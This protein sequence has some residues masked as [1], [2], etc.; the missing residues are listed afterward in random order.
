MFLF[1]PIKLTKILA[2][3][4]PVLALLLYGFFLAHKTNL[5]TSDLGRHIKNGEIVFENPKILQTNFYSYTYPDY[6]TV[7]HHWL[8]GVIFFAIWKLSGFGGLHLFSILLNLTT[9]LIFFRVAQKKAGA[10][11]AALIA[12]AIIPLLT[13]RSE[14]R[15]EILSYFFSALFFQ[16]MIRHRE[17]K[18]SAKSLLIILPILEIIWANSHIYFFLGPII[19]SVFLIES[20]ILKQ[21]RARVAIIAL[22]LTIAATLI[23]PAFIKGM[24]APLNIFKNYGYRIVE[25]QSVWFIEK[26]LPNPNYLIFKIIFALLIIS[27][28][29]RFLKNRRDIPITD[30]LLA[31]GFSL[32][33]WLAIRNFAIFGFFALPVMAGNFAAAYPRLRLNDFKITAGAC[34]ILILFLLSML[35]GELKKIHP[36]S[37]FGLGIEKNNDLA[38]KFIQREKITGP[39][40]NNYDIGSFL[41]FYLWPQEKVFVDNRPEAYPADFLSKTYVPMQENSKIW[42]SEDQKYHFNAIIFSHQDYTPWGQN[43]LAERLKDLDWTPVFIDN[44]IIIFLKN[45]QLNQRLIAKFALPANTRTAQ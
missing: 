31:S 38:A 19:I 32:A 1:P 29:I 18:L 17:S 20:I 7:N 14:I 44:H 6:P 45:N 11:L 36:Y 42:A 25:N 13:E 4:A 24:L 41:I 3:L 30:I 43:F 26:L 10:G 39:I 16:L 34:V 27:F 35:S 22:L 2:I 37:D 9:L 28:A 40:F 15:P 21:N 5:V 8:S 33:A 23:N 12:L